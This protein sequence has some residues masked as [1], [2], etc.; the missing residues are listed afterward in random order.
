MTSELKNEIT[1]AL[2]LDCN[3]HQLKQKIHKKYGHSY[4]LK[5]YRNLKEK[6][7]QNPESR[8]K[9]AEFVKLLQKQNGNNLAGME[10]LI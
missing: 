6:L 2:H 9:L 3:L 5:F 4:E 10:Y 1:D 8:N 7:K